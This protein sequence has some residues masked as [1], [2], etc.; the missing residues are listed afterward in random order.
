MELQFFLGEALSMLPS[1]LGI[2][3]GSYL[4]AV[5]IVQVS[6]QPPYGPPMPGSRT[7]PAEAIALPFSPGA[8]TWPV[9]ES[10][11]VQPNLPTF[12]PATTPIETA[13]ESWIHPRNWFWPGESS[14]GVELGL[15]GS[16]GNSEALS[17]KTGF[18]LR[19]KMDVHDLKFDLTYTKA[20][21]DGVQTQ[22]NALFNASYEWTIGESKWE[23]FV[24][25]ALEYDEFKAFNVRFAINAGVG[26]Q[27]IRTDSTTWTTRFGAGASTEIGGPTDEWVPEGVLGFDFE[28]HL[29]ERQTISLTSDYFPD[30]SNFSNYR[31]VTKASYEILLNE[32]HNLNLKMSM[33]DRYDSTPNGAKPND[34]DYSV[35]LLWKK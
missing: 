16:A 34:I 5:A 26:Y 1:R 29:S 33:Q 12:A 10:I 17:L 14:G 2:L 27:L 20:T 23:L 21:A 31:I 3:L 24:K 8:S 11:N 15:S 19:R 18:E 13:T 9:E 28:R 6:A 4:F 32:E 25:E 7:L 35:L 22:H 30:W